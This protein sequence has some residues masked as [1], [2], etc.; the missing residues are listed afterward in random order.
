[1]ATSP[2]VHPDRHYGTNVG[3][4]FHVAEVDVSDSEDEDEGEGEGAAQ[5][6]AGKAA[7]AGLDAGSGSRAP[8]SSIPEQE[9]GAPRVPGLASP[10]ELA[11]RKRQA[12]A[13]LAEKLKAAGGGDGHNEG[14]SGRQ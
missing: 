3:K 2:F 9:S 1:M 6:A 14:G 10:L 11:R 12:Q 5:E 13:R 4:V 7:A 8:A